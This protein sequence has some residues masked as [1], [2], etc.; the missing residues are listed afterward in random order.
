MIFTH[1]FKMGTNGT[2]ARYRVEENG[3]SYMVVYFGGLD[4][5]H[6]FLEERFGEG[7]AEALYTGTCNYPISITYQLGINSYKGKTE[8]QIVM[9]N[10]C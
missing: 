9:Q 1:G 2:F 10:F 3:R 4:K 5:F 7:A 6:G 8:V